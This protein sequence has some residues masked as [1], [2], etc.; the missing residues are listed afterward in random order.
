MIF[1]TGSTG[2]VGRHLLPRLKE[3]GHP[4]RCFVR[5]GSKTECLGDSCEDKVIGDVLDESS[6]KYCM[7]GIDTVIHLAGV[8]MESGSA[9]FEGVFYLGTR[10]VIDV[11][12][13]AGV[14]QFIL[15]SAYGA[16][17][18]APSKYHH[19]KWLAEEYL[20]YSGLKYV[21]FRPTVIYGP[22]DHF[23]TRWIRKLKALPI[24]PVLGNGKNLLQPIGV[25]DVVRC[26]LKAMEDPTKSQSVY[27]LAGP[28]RLT[29]EEIIH[30]IGGLMGR[31]PR[32]FHW[33][34]A[35]VRAFVRF[36][37]LVIPRPPFTQDEVL[38]WMENRV[39]DHEVV[40]QEF[41]MKLMPF[42]EGL[43][44]YFL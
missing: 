10:H 27:E 13:A 34:L 42:R 14:K 30:L 5:A 1:L 15:F 26:V 29:F 39:C 7:R 16:R 23:V 35:L 32:L 2:F 24:I 9:S 4:V 3:K 12:K 20:R 38:R 18:K 8:R 33:P 22:H 21:I 25:E 11:A 37:E 43:K 31:R 6:L 44:K 28:D 17:P 19:A 40:E 41:G 36:T